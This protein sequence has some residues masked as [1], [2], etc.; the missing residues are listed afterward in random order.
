M[1]LQGFLKMF[2][3]EN[4]CVFE[5]RAVLISLLTLWLCWVQV[6][7]SPA[8]GWLPATGPPRRQVPRNLLSQDRSFVAPELRVPYSC[9]IVTR[10]AGRR[11]QIG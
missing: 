6:W 4:M 11:L 9:A 2:K 3:L 5:L 8:A 10:R 1:Y 7:A